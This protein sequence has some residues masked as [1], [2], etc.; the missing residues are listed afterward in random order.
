MSTQMVNL[1]AAFAPMVQQDRSELMKEIRELAQE[2]NAIILA[3]NYQWPDVQDVADTTGDSL[4][5]ALEAPKTNA[6][7]IVFCGVHFMAESAKVLNPEKRVLLPNLSAGCSLADSISPESLEEWKERYPGYTVVTY[8]N[9]TAEVKAMSDICCTSA[10]AVAV[11]RSLPTDKIL[12]T[13]DRNLGNWVKK[14]VPEK[15]IAIYDGACPTHDVLRGANVQKVRGQH[16]DAVVIA[17]PECRED[18]IAIADEVCSTTAMLGRIARYPH[19]KTFIVATESG[20]IHQMQ[21][22]YP[23][24]EFV[25]ADGCIGCRLHCPYMK[26]I[27]LEDVRRSLIED[28]FEITVDPEVAAGARRALD[29]MLAVPRDN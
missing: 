7:V 18:I 26:M 6:D 12:F 5:L 23:D 14:Q 11:V 4:G 27:G 28:K 10:N 9:S 2:R 1:S 3:H 22:Q 15:D 13:P 8:V 29:R 20:I 21:K 19:T 24:R 25:M 16:P 17:H